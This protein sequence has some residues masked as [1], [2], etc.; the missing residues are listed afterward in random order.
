MKKIISQHIII[1]LLKASDKKVLKVAKGRW[2]RESCYVQKKKD[3]C[4]NGFIV[5]MMETLFLVRNCDSFGSLQMFL[6]LWENN[7]NFCLCLYTGFSY[8]CLCHL[9][10]LL[11]EHLSLDLGSILIVQDDLI[12][13]FSIL[14]TKTLFPNKIKFTD[15]GAWKVGTTFEGPK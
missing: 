8:M 10:C 4:V 2:G 11:Q 5:E 12:W 6:G 14:S 13:R 15:S 9:F 1:K 3:K 7:S